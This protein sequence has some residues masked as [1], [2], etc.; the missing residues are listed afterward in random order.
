MTKDISELPASLRAIINGSVNALRETA[1]RVRSR[2]AE[3]GKPVTYPIDW[4]SPKQRRF[5]MAKLR[6]ENNLPYRRTG[7]YEAS[8]KVKHKP[9]GATVF[10]P[11]PAG[12]IGGLP[13]GWQSRIHRNRWNYLTRVLFEELAKL[14]DE[15][16]NQVRVLST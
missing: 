1:G 14:P 6:R 3:T 13:G 5:V 16:S 4:D 12:A 7:R 2:M 8:W 9:F 10:A 11:H 15:I